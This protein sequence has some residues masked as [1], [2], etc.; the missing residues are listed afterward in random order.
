[1]DVGSFDIAVLRARFPHLQDGELGALAAC[2]ARSIGILLTDDLA[3]REAARIVGVVP[4]GSIG[5]VL[6]AAKI[7]LLGNDRAQDML[8]RLASES[9]LFTTPALIEGAVRALH[10]GS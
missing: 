3:A 9:T 2:E 8:L 4:V 10:S 6:R 7:G 1:M 5:V